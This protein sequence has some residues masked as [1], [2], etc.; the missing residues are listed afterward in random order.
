M[1]R[2][3]VADCVDEALCER[4]VNETDKGGDGSTPGLVGLCVPTIAK[5]AATFVLTSMKIKDNVVVKGHW[6]DLLHCRHCL[7]TCGCISDWIQ[8]SIV[9]SIRSMSKKQILQES[10]FKIFIHN[11]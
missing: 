9:K 7:R 4:Y 6:K 3:K 2:Y 10:S 1:E 5:L 8:N 11:M